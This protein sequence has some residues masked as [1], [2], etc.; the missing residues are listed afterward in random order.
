MSSC[1]PSGAHNKPKDESTDPDL[2][3]VMKYHD[4]SLAKL[5]DIVVVQI[6]DRRAK[7]RVVFLGGT[8]EHLSLDDD[9]VEWVDREELLDPSQVVLEWIETNP[10]AH[11]DP[12]YAPVGNYM[13]TRLD[14]CV[15]RLEGGPERNA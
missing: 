1:G 11:A 3:P 9:F 14:C 4:G 6:A 15:T 7:A 5:G 10:F 2:Y 12:R 8:R 13:F